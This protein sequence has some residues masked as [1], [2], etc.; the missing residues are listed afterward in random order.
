[1]EGLKQAFDLLAGE[2][3][4][5][6]GWW[7]GEGRCVSLDVGDGFSLDLAIFGYN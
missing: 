5:G 4:G 2:V 3:G 6:G 1:M 7:W